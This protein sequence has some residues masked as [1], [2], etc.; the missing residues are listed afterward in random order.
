MLTLPAET[1]VRFIVWMLIGLV[2]YF[3]YSRN[4]SRLARGVQSI[5]APDSSKPGPHDQHGDSPIHE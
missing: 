2:V 5:P 4:H 3:L 1:W